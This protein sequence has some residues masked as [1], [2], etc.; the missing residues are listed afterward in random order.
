MSQTMVFVDTSVLVEILAV[1]GKCQ[2]SEEIRE[3]LRDRVRAGESLLLPTAAIIET[4][5]HIAQL[6]DG[7]QRRTLV[8]HFT[9]LLRGI[10]SGSAPWV[11]NAARWDD[12]LLAAIC[13]GARGCPPLPEMATQGVGAGDVSILAEAEA[14]EARTARVDV[15]IWTLDQ[16]LLAYA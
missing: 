9:M 8:E 10:T 2:R 16:G 5:N 15:R 13:G 12:D 14:Y 4:G 6:R 11:L 1:P 3:E 7:T